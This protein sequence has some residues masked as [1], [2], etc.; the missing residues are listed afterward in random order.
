VKVDINELLGRNAPVNDPSFCEEITKLF[1]QAINRTDHEQLV[2]L[3]RAISKAKKE[4][5]DPYSLVVLD[6]S[7]DISLRAMKKLVDSAQEKVR[8]RDAIIAERDT[9]IEE[10]RRQLK[11]KR[12]MTFEDGLWAQAARLW[13]DGKQKGL[14]GASIADIADRLSRETS[15]TIT[16]GMVTQQFLNE[17]PPK[18]LNAV[19][20]KGAVGTDWAELWA[21][22]AA[23]RSYSKGSG[24]RERGWLRP[25]QRRLPGLIRGSDLANIDMNVV[26]QLRDEY[27]GSEQGRRDEA[28]RLRRAMEDVRQATEGQLSGTAKKMQRIAAEVLD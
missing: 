19:V 28:D 5:L 26:K 6:T 13:L 3:G 10:L 4:G 7:S 2:A 1:V 11:A 23:L 14:D 17:G 18:G 16:V 25:L 15:Q 9:E 27:H 20:R 22:G 12:G 21:L 24:R 8:Q